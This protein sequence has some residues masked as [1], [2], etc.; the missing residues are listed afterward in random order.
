MYDKNKRLILAAAH[1]LDPTP[2]RD[3]VQRVR[4]MGS[5]HFMRTALSRLREGSETTENISKVHDICKQ[6]RKLNDAQFNKKY[7]HLDALWNTGVA[8]PA[9]REGI[10]LPKPV[11]TPPADRLALLNKLRVKAKLEPLKAWKASRQS[12]EEAIDKAKKKIASDIPSFQVHPA[13]VAEGAYKSTQEAIMKTGHSEAG[14]SKKV[15]KN[16]AKKQRIVEKRTSHD[17]KLSEV[18]GGKKLVA[19]VKEAGD[20]ITLADIAATLGMLPKVARAKARKNKAKIAKYEIKGTKYKFKKGD[21]KN[22]TAI[23][24]A[25]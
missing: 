17:I 4:A 16:E 22:V 20:T 2:T 10:E 21:L 24:E 13:V 5:V 7:P 23:L 25:K 1:V 19:A 14:K 15:E 18:K 11:H 9:S 8:R 12:L 3:E 6:W